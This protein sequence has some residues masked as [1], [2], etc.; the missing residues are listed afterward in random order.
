MAKRNV[1]VVDADFEVQKLI[2]EILEKNNF[3]VFQAYSGEE[4]L[5]ILECHNIDLITLDIV[6]PGIDGLEIL[7]KIR[8]HPIFHALPILILT[9]KNS[10]IDNVIGLEM[11][12]DDYIGK[13]IRYH[14]LLARIKSVLR[15][16]DLNRHNI[17]RLIKLNNLEIDL[18]TRTVLFGGNK[19][20][21]SFKE[22]ELLCLLAKNPGRVFSR[23]E[24]LN[25]VWKEEF[26]LETRTVDVHIRRL[27]QKFEDNHENDI[28]IETVR[29]VG[30]RLLQPV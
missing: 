11:G 29:N 17:T 15:R 30:Y 3:N 26:T 4:A 19:V 23:D 12:A 18:G 2:N 13:P 24:I 10:E 27:R 14:E 5:T 21:L 8:N 28:A 1:L 16:T 20:Y 22:F 7:K 25:L 9:F 6:L